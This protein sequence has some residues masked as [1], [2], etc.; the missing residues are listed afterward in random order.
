MEIQPAGLSLNTNTAP[1]AI[2]NSDIEPMT[3]QA[4]GCGTA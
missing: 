1:S 2:K 4:M 3:G